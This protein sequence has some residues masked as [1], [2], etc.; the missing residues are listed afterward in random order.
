LRFS[1][2]LLE[3][4]PLD[5]V[6]RGED[7]RRVFVHFQGRRN[8]DPSRPLAT[9]VKTALQRERGEPPATAGLPSAFRRDSPGRSEAGWPTLSFCP[10][11]S[12]ST[13][14]P[15]LTARSAWRRLRDSEGEQEER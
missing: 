2:T 6:V 3:S 11:E 13:C 1:V 10:A 12:A 9:T 7:V 8:P 4:V 5:D 15:S 14:F